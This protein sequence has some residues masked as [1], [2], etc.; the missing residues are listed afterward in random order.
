MEKGSRFTANEG[1]NKAMEQK[2][3]ND[4]LLIER[5]LR[6]ELSS[7]EAAA[8]EEAYL[9]SGELLDDLEAAEKLQQGLRDVAVLEKSAARSSRSSWIPSIFSSPQYAMAASFLLVASLG[10]SGLLY[11]RVG[12]LDG[13]TGT[14]GAVPTQI[15][16]LVS[17]RGLPGSE[18]L[19]TIQLDPDTHAYVLMLDPGFEPYSHYR[20]SVYEAG[21]GGA[22][23]L[24]LQANNLTPGYE[25]MLALSIPASMLEPGEFD[26]HVEGWREEWP[27][28]HAFAPVDV[29]TL[30]VLRA[31]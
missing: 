11:Q 28:E 16:P 23:N 21:S 13:L 26:I 20:A 25:D 7:A 22:G 2:Y 15:V 12:E 4:N 14:P 29:L 5:Y 9:G 8:F 10:F 6:D 24:I 17:V 27:P 3:I 18:P 31:N 30:R 1:T 19:N